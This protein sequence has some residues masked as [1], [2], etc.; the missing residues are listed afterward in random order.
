MAEKMVSAWLTEY[1]L[2]CEWLVALPGQL[3]LIDYSFHST[4]FQI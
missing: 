2:E 1:I 4:G 3:A